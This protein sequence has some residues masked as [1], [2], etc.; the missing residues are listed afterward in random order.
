V[1]SSEGKREEAGTEGRGLYGA[2]SDVGFREQI[3]SLVLAFLVYWPTRVESKSAQ[4]ATHS[5]ENG[6]CGGSGSKV[7]VRA[8]L[9]LYGDYLF[10][11]LRPVLICTPFSLPQP[12]VF[13]VPQP[14]VNTA[15]YVIHKPPFLF[16]SV[17]RTKSRSADFTRPA[18]RDARHAPETLMHPSVPVRDDR[19]PQYL[20]RHCIS[21]SVTLIT[22]PLT[23]LPTDSPTWVSQSMYIP[24]LIG[25]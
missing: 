25:V 19:A 5:K 4:C 24:R 23:L 8:W 16:V 17:S 6:G 2:L 22:E 11:R 12:S 20:C 10:T 18:S 13:S 21:L 14:S 15:R 3:G 9:V 1:T 7:E